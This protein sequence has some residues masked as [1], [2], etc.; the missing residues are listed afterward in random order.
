MHPACAPTPPALLRAVAA[1]WKLR[2]RSKGLLHD[3]AGSGCATQQ[4]SALMLALALRQG[5]EQGHM[6]PLVLA[7]LVALGSLAGLR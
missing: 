5:Q 7:A 2:L 6:D 1:R 3:C 4:A